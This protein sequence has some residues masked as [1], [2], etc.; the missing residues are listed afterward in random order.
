MMKRAASASE[1]GA[2]PGQIAARSARPRTSAD[3]ATEA[4]L[5]G[6]R[7]RRGTNAITP[8]LFNSEKKDH[9]AWNPEGEMHRNRETSK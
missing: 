5:A 2:D 1:R 7:E 3:E 8:P 9:S 4:A 6:E